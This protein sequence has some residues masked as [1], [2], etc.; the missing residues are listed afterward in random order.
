M[1]VW[2]PLVFV[3]LWSTGFVVAALVAP[4]AEPLSILTLRFGGAAILLL[5]FGLIMR[6]VW[7]D[8][9]RA[10]QIVVSGALIHGV[11]L[12]WVF[13]AVK[14]GMPA[15]VS[16]LLVGLQPLL[17]AIFASP[18]LGEKIS[19]RH[20]AGLL[21]GILGCA[22]VVSPKLGIDGSGIN[23]FTIGAHIIAVFGIVFGSIFQKKYIGAMNFKTEPGLQLIGG[24]LVAL[25]IALLTES[26]EFTLSRDLIIGYLWMTAILSCMAFTLY[27]Y[28]L[29]QDGATKVASVFYLVPAFAAFEGYLLFGDTLTVFQLIGMAVTTLAVALASDMF[30]RKRT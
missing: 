25:P 19:F 2:L 15:G 7:P 29:Q 22:M 1:G 12:S 24:F 13:W 8:R 23:T 20:W 27:M 10:L 18:I 3:F 9:R 30:A 5:L 14:N 11:Y 21:I 26:F 17:T 28:L 16:A 4:Y 6:G